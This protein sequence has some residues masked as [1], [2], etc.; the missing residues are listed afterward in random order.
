MKRRAPGSIEVQI[1][2]SALG[3]EPSKLASFNETL[4]RRLHEIFPN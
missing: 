2:L 4:E 1:W 3:L